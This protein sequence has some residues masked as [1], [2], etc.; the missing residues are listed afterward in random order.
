MFSILK[1]RFGIPGVISVIALAFAMMGGA[2][3]A[4]SNGG[5]SATASAK[6]KAKRGPTGPKGATGQPGPVGPQ[7]PAGANGKDGAVG[8]AGPTGPVGSVGPAGPTETTLP[9][10]KTETGVWF[11]EGDGAGTSE[12]HAAISYPL[13]L[14]FDPTFFWVP[15]SFG[16][17]QPIA[18]HCEGTWQEPTA[19]AGDLCV[20]KR[21]I[22]NVDEPTGPWSTLNTRSGTG[23]LF[24]L[25]TPGSFAQ[26]LGTWAVTAPTS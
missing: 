2:Y 26:A 8:P 7:G 19:A 25:A 1:N 24:N 23:L 6:K 16:T 5:G 18:D 15:A 10:G 22:S 9:S 13:R 3:A 4:S 17:T 21:S 14:T 11:T 12:M 20:Y